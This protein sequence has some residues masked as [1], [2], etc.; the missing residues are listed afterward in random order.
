M[1]H[2]KNI[3]ILG[4]TG[5]IGKSALEVVRSLSQLNIVGLSGHSRLDILVEQAREFG[6]DHVVAADSEIAKNFLFPDLPHSHVST[7]PEALEK[8]A[9]DPQVDIVLAAIVGIAGLPSTW[10]AIKSGKRVAL[11]NKE[12]LVVAGELMTR[13]AETTGAKILPVDSEHSAVFQCL[14]GGKSSELQRLILTAS[15]NGSGSSE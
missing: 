12:T 6:P 10:A 5:S 3:A 9:A 4:S 8:L 15:G 2:S 13:M 7:G 11:A 14:A 1:T